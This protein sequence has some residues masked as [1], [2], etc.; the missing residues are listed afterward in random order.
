MYSATSECL[1]YLKRVASHSTKESPTGLI[2]AI[3]WWTMRPETNTLVEEYRILTA[4]QT[5]ADD[6][7]LRRLF[8]SKRGRG[9]EYELLTRIR[10]Y[11]DRVVRTEWQVNR[12]SGELK[13]INETGAPDPK[14]KKAFLI[15]LKNNVQTLK[16]KQKE[17]EL[18]WLDF[19]LG[20]LQGQGLETMGRYEWKKYLG[21]Q[22]L[23]PELKHRP[24]NLNFQRKNKQKKP[25]STHHSGGR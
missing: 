10:K 13:V 25:H 15:A 14:N 16:M 20:R 18:L 23:G 1:N 12:I 21:K 2:R 5:A 24:N 3:P 8:E 9:P 17:L 11:M 4:R 7:R 19:R 22:G 6:L